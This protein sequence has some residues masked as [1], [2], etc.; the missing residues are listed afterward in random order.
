MQD[1]IV[2]WDSPAVFTFDNG[3]KFKLW[4]ENDEFDTPGS[5]VIQAK[6]KY[7]D[8]PES[9]TDPNQVPEPTSM[10]L[11]GAGLVGLAALKRKHN[12]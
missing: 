4:L 11:L 8:A 9:N 1:G 12:K 6:F 5:A 3:G 2:R 7:I 10:L